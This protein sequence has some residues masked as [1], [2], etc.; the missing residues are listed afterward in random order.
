MKLIETF[1]G[2][3][4]I[5]ILE[6]TVFIGINS[7]DKPN[8]FPFQFGNKILKYMKGTKNVEIQLDYFCFLPFNSGIL[9][10]KIEGAPIRYFNYLDFTPFT[11]YAGY[12]NPL[13]CKSLF[14]ENFR[15]A[16][17]DIDNAKKSYLYSKKHGKIEV[18]TVLIPVIWEDF[19]MYYD[20]EERIIY[21]ISLPT[22]TP[23]W[24]YRIPD[25]IIIETWG[26]LFFADQTHLFLRLKMGGILAFDLFTGEILW[27][28]SRNE[29]Y[30]HCAAIDNHIYIN[31]GK[32]LT[33]VNVSTGKTTRFLNFREMPEMDGFHANGSIFAFNDI[34]VFKDS[35][36][37]EIAVIDR[38]TFKL[39]GRD[40]V[41]PVGIAEAP[42]V[43]H[44][45]DGYLYVM[46]MSSKVNIYKVFDDEN[47][48]S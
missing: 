17:L 43:I 42:K 47:D 4:H 2:A 35:R 31:A 25:D 38:N 5:D 1:F 39:I 23:A 7:K 28:W 18:A 19:Y 24:T 16:S 48:K 12:F 29:E 26:D 22:N 46:G 40:I 30:G 45:V 15:F 6:N 3:T 33:E 20:R 27:Q 21:V 36:S 9:S 34:L 41:D 11:E 44:Y 13:N 10:Y 8:G 37:A 14:S 32:S